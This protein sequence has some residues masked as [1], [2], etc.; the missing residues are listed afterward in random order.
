[1]LQALPDKEEARQM[2]DLVD[3]VKAPRV[4]VI[5]LARRGEQAKAVAELH[6]IAEPLARIDALSASLLQGQARE[7]KVA[8]DQ[9]DAL[10]RRWMTA[11]GTAA[12]VGLLAG[13]LLYR[14]LMSRFARADLM[15]RL[16][17]E[18]AETASGL[19]TG[20]RELDA[21]NHEVGETNARLAALLQQ[22]QGSCT[23]ITGEAARSLDELDRL[24]A[25]CQRSAGHSREHATQAA[26]LA[27]QLSSTSQRMQQLLASSE[28]L[29]RS[30]QEIAGFAEQI[31]RIAAT[32]RLLSLNAAVEAARAGPAGRG[33]SVIA[34]SVRE[35]AEDTQAAA[36]HIRRS[37]E[38]INLQLGTA[39]EAIR[40]TATLMD[41]CAGRIAALDGTARANR[42]LAEGMAGDV[43]GFRGSFERQAGRISSL[44]SQAGQLD[45]A[46]REGQRHAE[47]LERTSRGLWR[48]SNALHQRLSGLQA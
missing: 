33:F 9:R 15:E 3:S 4:Q 8:A 5:V 16:L 28:A 41:D 31:G 44:E 46:L 34:S 39:A 7:R 30:R 26:V 17:E 43:D 11:L 27:E 21:L 23:D 6:A 22:L 42:Q 48:S 19:D 1:L 32:T 37:S 36:V 20:G 29:A 45:E 35:L 14:R 25:A 12:A 24:S 47:L 13:C 2:R 10:M 38:D 18:V 40:H